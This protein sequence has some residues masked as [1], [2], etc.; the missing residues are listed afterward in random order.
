MII[1]GITGPTGAGKTTALR[2]IEKLGGRVIDEQKAVEFV[3]IFLSTGF[4][5]GRH[6]RRVDQ[7]AAVERGEL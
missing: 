3:K 1:I 5:G 4:E 7:I 6:Q 2:E